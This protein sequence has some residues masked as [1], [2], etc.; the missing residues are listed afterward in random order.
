MCV[1]FCLWWY[2]WVVSVLSRVP[3]PSKKRSGFVIQKQPL[4]LAITKIGTQQYIRS[5][6]GPVKQTPYLC[7][8]GTV[9]GN[10]GGVK[11]EIRLMEQQT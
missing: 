6:A 11:P 8:E 9:Y 3:K 1:S 4:D 10:G 5:A 7:P 2:V